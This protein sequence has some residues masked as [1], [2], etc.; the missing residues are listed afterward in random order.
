MFFFYILDF[1]TT[2]LFFFYCYSGFVFFL[3]LFR[4]L[5]PI[6]RIKRGN[7]LHTL[8]HKQ[9]ISMAQDIGWWTPVFFHNLFV[10]Q[11]SLD[12][13]SPLYL[14]SNPTF[15]GCKPIFFLGHCLFGV[16]IHRFVWNVHRFCVKFLWL[17]VSTC[18]TYLLFINHTWDDWLRL[19]TPPDNQR[20][21]GAQNGG[22]SSTHQFQQQQGMFGM[23]T[24]KQQHS[25][26]RTMVLE[27]EHLQNTG[28]NF[29]PFL[30]YPLVN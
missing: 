20:W 6:D 29:D 14:S 19:R 23:V 18:F 3:L 12:P 26:M 9:P 7:R 30:G 5:H 10:G 8:A 16:G 1:F 15:I 2:I 4:K 24:T 27:Y 11:K 21:H 17:M 25:Q 13:T 28:S 22:F